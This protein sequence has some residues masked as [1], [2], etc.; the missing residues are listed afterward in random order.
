MCHEA[1]Y[2]PNNRATLRTNARWH[3][4]WSSADAQSRVHA[5]EHPPTVELIA[6]QG[7]IMATFD[8][9]AYGAVGNGSTDDTGSIQK[10]IDT[11]TAEGGGR[12]YFPRGTYLITAPLVLGMRLILQGDG[13]LVSSIRQQSAGVHGLLMHAPDP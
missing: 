9:T 8:V 11:A 13:P 4:D 10:A 2:G 1:P 7:V 12:V 5:M 6:R 3:A